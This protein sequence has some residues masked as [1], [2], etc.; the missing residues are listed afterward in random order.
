MKNLSDRRA[1]EFKRAIGQAKR[2]G[3]F[4]KTSVFSDNHPGR[5]AV[6]LRYGAYAPIH[7]IQTNAFSLMRESESWVQFGRA[8]QWT[9]CSAQEVQR[10]LP[11]GYIKIEFSR[12]VEMGNQSET[13]KGKTNGC[14]ALY[15]CSSNE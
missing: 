11:G 3:I 9:F 8:D 10:L 14:S 7:R 5:R 15:K 13:G 1:A 2:Q 4:I 12:P 6:A